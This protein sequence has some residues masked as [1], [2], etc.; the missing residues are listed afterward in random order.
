MMSAPAPDVEGGPIVAKAAAHAK[1]S[2]MAAG[3]ASTTGRM[4]CQVVAAQDL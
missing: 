2:R 1:L 4:L 3:S